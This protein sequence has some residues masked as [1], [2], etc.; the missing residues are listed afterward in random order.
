[1]T[2]ASGGALTAVP[3][4][5]MSPFLSST[6]PL[7]NSSPLTVT[8]WASLMS[9]VD[10]TAECRREVASATVTEARLSCFVKGIFRHKNGSEFTLRE[11]DEP[12]QRN[13]Y[14]CR[15]FRQSNN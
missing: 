4:S 12:S 6:D 7:V 1:M 2:Q 13:R 3:T 15:L 9:T 5:W 8:M 11:K 10:G 14:P